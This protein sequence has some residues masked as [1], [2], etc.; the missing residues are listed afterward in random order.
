VTRSSASLGGRHPGGEVVLDL[1]FD[2]GA[3]LGIDF[4]M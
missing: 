4:L 3:K 2:V 1:H